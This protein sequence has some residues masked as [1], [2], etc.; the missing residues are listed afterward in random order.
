[1]SPLLLAATLTITLAF[2]ANWLFANTAPLTAIKT[3]NGMCRFWFFC[4]CQFLQ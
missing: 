4:L 1:M 3:F 2:F